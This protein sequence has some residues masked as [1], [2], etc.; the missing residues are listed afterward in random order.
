MKKLQR[1]QLTSRSSKMRISTSI[2]AMDFT[3]QTSVSTAAPASSTNITKP[4]SLS[5]SVLNI[6]TDRGARRNRLKVVMGAE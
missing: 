1:H 3:R 5:A 2:S 4:R 6:I